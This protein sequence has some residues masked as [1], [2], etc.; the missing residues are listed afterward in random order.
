M[1]NKNIKH[2]EVQKYKIN[3]IQYMSNSKHIRF[4]DYVYI[5][6]KKLDEYI[7]NKQSKG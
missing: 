1:E 4:E 6:Q 2:G 7:K 5:K 3:F